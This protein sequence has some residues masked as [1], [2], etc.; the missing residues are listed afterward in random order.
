MRILVIGGTLFIGRAL[1]ARLLKDGHDVA[2]LHRKPTHDLGPPVENIQGDRNEP[3]RAALGGRRFDAVF[4]NVYD[5]QRRTTA[6]QIARTVD[7]VGGGLRRYIFMSSVAAYGN[8]FDVA[9]DAPLAPDDDPDL[10]V[11]DKA[12]SERFLLGL[13]GFP[14]VT[15]RPPF[16]YG[17]GNPYYREA[18]FWQRFA[19][20]RSVILPD[21]GDRLMQFI[22]VRDLAGCAVECLYRESA[23]GQAFNIA[24]PEPVSQKDLVSALAVAAGVEARTVPMPRHELLRLGGHPTGPKFYFGE[25]F[26]LPPITQNTS[27]AQSILGFRATPFIEGLRET[28]QSFR[29]APSMD[30]AFEDQALS[31]R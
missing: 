17:P 25:Y 9:E 6:E 31:V 12:Q 19:D 29:P 5:W 28:W 13:A 1:V 15:L 24:N 22:H 4:D 21:G 11:R 20:N 2:V 26:D 7:A 18:F 16:I 10:Y 3:L 27:K 8:G 30:Y 23:I 14:A